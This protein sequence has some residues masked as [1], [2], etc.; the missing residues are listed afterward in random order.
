MEHAYDHDG[1]GFHAVNDNERGAG[2]HKFAGE[3]IE[4]STSFAVNLFRPLFAH[5]PPAFRH[6][7]MVDEFDLGVVGLAQALLDLRAEPR[8]VLARLPLALDEVAHQLAH[9]FGS[10]TIGGRSFCSKLPRRFRH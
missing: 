3:A 1:R 10:R 9:E 2:Y 4:L 7:L 6:L 8:V 5:P